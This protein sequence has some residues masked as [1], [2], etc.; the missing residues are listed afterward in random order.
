MFLDIAVKS[1]YPMVGLDSVIKTLFSTSGFTFVGDWSCM[2]ACRT[3]LH[4]PKVANCFAQLVFLDT[5][6]HRNS[7]L[8]CGTACTVEICFYCFSGGR[9]PRV[10]WTPCTLGTVHDT[11]VVG[12]TICHILVGR[13]PQAVCASLPQAHPYYQDFFWNRKQHKVG[14]PEWFIAIACIDGWF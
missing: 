12:S 2:P 6:R 5:G 10:V 1:V 4:H 8:V 7:K 13:L 14:T 3:I 9:S 11:R